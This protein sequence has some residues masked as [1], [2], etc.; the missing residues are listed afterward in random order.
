MCSTDQINIVFDGEFA[1]D[2]LPESEADTSIV[3]SE[4]FDPS[5]WVRPQQIAQE[6][7][8]RHIGRSHY[9]LDLF[10]IFEFGTQA[11]V[12]TKNL[13]VYERTD[14]Q[15]IKD[16]REYLPKLDRVS[17]LALIVETIDPVDLGTLVVSSQEKEILRVL[18]LVAEQQGNGLDRLLASVNIVAQEEIISFGWEATILKNPQ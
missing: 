9:V 10:E 15:A 2:A 1:Y 6:A 7:L 16:V 5:L 12:H 17:S 11:P 3:F 13:F 14:W 8:V 18:N 4:L